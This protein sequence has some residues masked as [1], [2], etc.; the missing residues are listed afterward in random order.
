MDYRNYPYSFPYNVEGP[1]M[2]ER[3]FPG[4]GGGGGGMPGFPP[5][6]PPGSPSGFP[7]G[8][9]PGQGQPGGGQQDGPPSSPP[10]SFT[11]QMQQQA[12]FGTFA[13]D[14]GAIR[15]CLRRFTFI[16]LENGR[17]FWFFP[18]FV[19]RTSVAGWRWR[20]FRWVFYGT[21]LN[22]IRSFQCY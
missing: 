11:P 12:S 5:G 20:G 13:V 6:F 2:D 21:D 18:T 3:I 10:P 4:G 16:W 15:G 22:R 19:G 7:P 14:P 1:I 17:S 9:P 8:F